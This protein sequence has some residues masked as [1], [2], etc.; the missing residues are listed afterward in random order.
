MKISPVRYVTPP[1]SCCSSDAVD[2]R[3]RRHNLEGTSDIWRPQFFCFLSVERD[4]LRAAVDPR[5]SRD[6]SDTKALG[7]LLLGLVL[8]RLFP[9]FFNIF[10]LSS[11]ASGDV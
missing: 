3:P 8:R 4:R 7:P 5:L 6:G 9:P 1:E 10:F 2:L 11:P